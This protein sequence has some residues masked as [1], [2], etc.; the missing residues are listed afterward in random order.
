MAKP[1]GLDFS[2][3]FFIKVFIWCTYLFV[4][5]PIIISLFE[6]W[7]VAWFFCMM[8]VVREILIWPDITIVDGGIVASHFG[9]SRLIT[10][11]KIYK[12][13]SGIRFSRIYFKE[14]HPALRLLRFFL[15]YNSFAVFRWR[16]NY[17]QALKI[18]DSEIHA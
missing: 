9:I 17:K 13:S 3:P 8:G 5:T 14:T 7:I 15:V 6:G 18:I 12:F 11:D 1:H 16:N 10:W 2:E 4:W